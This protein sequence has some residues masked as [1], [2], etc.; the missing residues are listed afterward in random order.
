MWYKCCWSG[1]GAKRTMSRSSVFGRSDYYY[2]VWDIS[3][4]LLHLVTWLNT[5]EGPRVDLLVT[6]ALQE[7]SESD[8]R[9]AGSWFS[10]R[11]VKKYGLCVSLF[12]TTE[13]A[14]TEIDNV[15]TTKLLTLLN[16]SATKVRKRKRDFD[17]SLALP[18]VKKMGGKRVVVSN[19]EEKPQKP[20]REPVEAGKDG[21]MVDIN[22]ETEAEG[23]TGICPSCRLS[24]PRRMY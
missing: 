6:V 24:V 4:Y 18:P 14:A 11:K 19:V 12:S 13:M 10:S 16:A 21:A 7:Y 20:E 8:I 22:D 2:A 3:W 15:V 1:C 9:A 5:L 23:T 17:D